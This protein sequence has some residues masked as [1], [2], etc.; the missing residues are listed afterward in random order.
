MDKQLLDNLQEFKVSIEKILSKIDNMINNDLVKEEDLTE[1]QKKD[2][3]VNYKGIALYLQETVEGKLIVADS[4][5]EESYYLDE[6]CFKKRPD[7]R[8]DY[9]LNNIS[10]WHKNQNLNGVN[11]IHCT[12]APIY[13]E[14]DP[15]S[16]E[17][18]H[19]V[20]YEG[21]FKEMVNQLNN[22]QLGDE[23]S[24]IIDLFD[25]DSPL[26]NNLEKEAM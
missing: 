3:F 6:L 18:L 24:D 15:R 26:P 22:M 8:L 21:R 20:N 25:P 4:V 5:S 9:I 12:E 23:M 17:V 7:I 11:V 1:E 14:Y 2:Y 10:G 13:W 16:D 19:V